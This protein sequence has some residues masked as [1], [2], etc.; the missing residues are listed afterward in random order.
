MCERDHLKVVWVH[1]IHEQKREVPKRNA[2]NGAS[3]ADAAHCFTDAGTSRDQIDRSL[4]FG[5]EAI[6]ETDRL[7]LVPSNVVTKLFFS[8]GVWPYR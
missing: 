5:P 4:N 3:S 1:A 8:F 6:S 2:T 7:V